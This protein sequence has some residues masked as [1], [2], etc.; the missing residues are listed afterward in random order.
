MRYVALT[1]NPRV[2]E[3]YGGRIEVICRPEDSAAALL[4]QGRDRLHLGWR[5]VNHPLTGSVKPNQTPYRSL[6]L[7][8]PDGPAGTDWASLLALE[9]SMACLERFAAFQPGSD[10]VLADLRMVDLALFDS[11]M[12]AL[13]R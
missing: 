1:N 7:E 4:V 9:D 13:S 11:A 3:K 6:L 2:E 10:E 12:A 8:Q 5:L